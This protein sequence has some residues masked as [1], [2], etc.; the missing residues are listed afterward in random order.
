MDYA[1][2]I[3][4][5]ISLNELFE[6]WKDKQPNGII[7]HAEDYFIADG[8]VDSSIWNDIEH[9]RI[10]FILKEAY[11]TDWGEATL[12]TWIKNSHPK[13]RMWKRVA[14]L[15]YGIQNTTETYMSK[16]RPQLSDK[17]HADALDQIAVVNLKK[18]NGKSTSN[19]D[20]IAEY[21]RYD[22]EEIKKELELIDADV[23]V[24]GST[25]KTLYEIV[26]EKQPLPDSEKND[27]WFYYMDL[28]G[29]RRL[30]IDFY[31]PA[32]QWPD[33]MNYYSLVSIYQQ[34]LISGGFIR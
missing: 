15:V 1:E 20:E 33:L 24:C 7:N 10:L 27:N 19:Y 4:Q 6:V 28:D 32:N 21:A 34:A 29:K 3:K 5:C 13:H 17:D 16:Y 9:K 11:G 18:S 26:Y 14:R 23:I 12:A 22:K 31:H 30:Y 2:R 25:F 8:I